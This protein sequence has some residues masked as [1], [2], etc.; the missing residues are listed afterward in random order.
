M[1]TR[2]PPAGRV[3]GLAAALLA[4][5]ALSPLQAQERTPDTR[6]PLIVIETLEEAAADTT[7]TFGARVSDDRALAGVALYHRREGQEAFVRT[8]MRP[9]GA[10]GD[11]AVAVPTDP[12]D[13][14][15]I[16]YYLQALDESGNRTVSGFAFDPLVRRLRPG[17]P[18]AAAAPEPAAPP[19]AS[20]GNARWWTLAL[21]VLAV[22]TLA[23][24]ADDGGGDGGDTV[25]LTVDLPAPDAR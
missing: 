23:A 10:S 11:F 7:Q 4:V 15:P 19:I 18:R 22:G 16:E 3:A 17:E 25:P 12:E 1:Q 2:P 14:R 13:L 21:G 20:S 6:A 5:L 24:L 9:R 8:P